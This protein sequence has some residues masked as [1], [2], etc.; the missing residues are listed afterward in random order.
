MCASAREK[1]PN[2]RSAGPH[3]L[4]QIVHLPMRRF[5]AIECCTR[6][7]L[8]EVRKGLDLTALMCQRTAFRFGKKKRATGKTIQ[9]RLDLELINHGSHVPGAKS[10]VNVNH[11]H[12]RGAGIQH[13]KQGSKTIEG[14]SIADAGGHRDYRHS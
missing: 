13:A 8:R 2:R 7:I 5:H 3:Y 4:S 1:I 11:A 9:S 6:K 12:V 14:C 10:I